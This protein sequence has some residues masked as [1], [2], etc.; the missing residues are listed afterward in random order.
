MNPRKHFVVIF[1]ALLCSVF[2]ADATADPHFGQVSLLLP[3]DGTHDATSTTDVSISG[4]SPVYNGDAKISAV[5]SKFGGTSCYFDGMGDYLI[6]ADSEDWNFGTGDFTIEFWVLRTGVSKF[7]GILGVNAAS[8]NSGAPVIVIYNTKILITEGDFSNKTRAA[9]SFIA[10]TWYHVAFSRSDGVMRL[11]VNGKLDGIAADAHSYD[12]NELRIGRYNVGADYDFG[13]YL[14]DIRITK[15]VA[16]YSS[17][18]ELPEAMSG[19]EATP[20]DPVIT[21]AK[22]SGIIHGTPLGQV[23]LNAVANVEGSF[24]YSP[25]AGTVLNSGYGQSLQVTFTPE[26]TAKYNVAEGRVTIDVAKATPIVTWFN[27]LGIEEGT[28]LD[29]TR[30]NATANVPGT[31]YYTPAAGTAL[32]VHTRL[33][34]TYSIYD[35]RVVFIAEDQSNYNAVG[36]KVQITVLPLAPEDAEPSILMEPEPITMIS[37]ESGQLSVTA[38]GEKPLA[39]QWYHNGSMIAGAGKATLK[40]EDAASEDGGDY[41]VV[42]M[43][44]L[45]AKESTAVTLTV[46]EPPV[47]VSDLESATIDIGASHQFNLVVEG[48]QPIEVEW[49]RNGEMLT[50]QDSLTLDI[51]AA[52]TTDGGEY[53]VRLKNDAGEHVS[54]PVKLSL[55][56]PVFI[57]TGLEDKSVTVGSDVVLK[58]LLQGTPPVSYKWYHDGNELRGETGDRLVLNSI[59]QLR[60][61]TYMVAAS[62]K[63]GSASSEAYLKV[64]SGP[65]IMR[66]PGDQSVNEG[67]NARFTVA[68]TGTKP[69][70]YQ[71]YYQGEAI[72]GATSAGFELAGVKSGNAGIYGVRISNF[73][74]EVSSDTARL[75]VNIPLKLVSDLEDAM[76]VIGG[77]ARF[78]VEVS[79]S[80]P[81]SYRWFKGG[82]LLSGASEGL[83]KLDQLGSEDS[84]LY[85]VEITN[86]AGTIRS[87]MARL[88]VV[89]GPT[90]AQAPVAQTVI[91]GQS[92][93]FSIIAGGSKPLT[94]Q[95]YRDGVSIEG[96]VGA[97][98][99]IE[100]AT[101]TDAGGYSV[102]VTNRGSNI[103]S[104]TVTLGVITPVSI[105]R[106]LEDVTVSEGG[107]ARFSVDASGTSPISYQWFYGGSP[108]DGATKSVY[109]IGIVAE[110]NR[111]IYQVKA[112]NGGGRASSAEAKLSVSVTPS[113]LR[114]MEDQELLAGGNLELQVSA[115]GTEP[116]TYNWYRG[117]DLYS[118]SSSAKL[119]IVGVTGQDGG[120]YQVEV[121]NAIGSV[122]STIVE[123]A[124]IEPATI[125]KHPVDTTVIQGNNGVLTVEVT[126]S[127]PINYQWYHNGDPLTG[128]TRA[129]LNILDAQVENSGTYEVHVSNQAGTVISDSVSLKLSIPPSITLQPRPFAGLTGE[130]LVIRIE[131]TGS[132]PLAYQWLKGGQAIAGQTSDSLVVE[133]VQE[134]DAGTYMV[135]VTNEAG[136]AT[137]DSALV[138]ITAPVAITAQ[139]Q[140]RAAPTGTSV[141]FSV[142]A[143]GTGSITYQWLKN[144][145]KITGAT[146]STYS[147]SSVAVSD[148]GGYQVLVSNGAGDQISQT[149]TLRVAQPVTIVTQPVSGQIRQGQ[150]YKLEVLASGTE[151]LS[152]QWTKDG[153]V[154]IGGTA[155][156]L[157]IVAAGVSDAGNYSVLIGNEVGDVIS[158]SATVEVL[159]PPSVGDM[160]ALK[161]VDPGSTV[162]LTTPVSG[163]GTFNYQWLKNGVNISGATEQTLVLSNVTLADSGSYS[164]NV[165]SEGGALYSNSMNLRVKADALAL[166]DAFASA[167]ASG[168]STGSY[169][170]SNVGAS[171]EVGEP[172]HGGRAASASV[173]TSWTAPANG[174]VSYSTQGSTFDTT[175]AVYTGSALDSLTLRAAD[176]DS[177]GYLTSRVRFNAIKDTVYHVAIDGFNGAT[178]DVALGWSL[179]ETASALPIIIAHPQSQTRVVGAQVKFD[180][181]LAPETGEVA[182]SW[183]KEGKWIVGEDSESL[184]LEY[185]QVADAGSYSVRVTSGGESVVSEVAQLTISLIED[186]PEVEV[187]TKLDLGAY[188]TAV[189]GDGNDEG[190]KLNKPILGGPDLLPRLIAKLR[191]I[192]KKPGEFSFAGSTV[193]NTT[194][195]A[196][197][198]GEPN[199]AGTTGGASAWTTFT[200][201]EEG[202]AKINTGN[203]DFDTVLAIYK[204]GSGT[205]WDAIEE[206]ASNND[207]GDDGQ[208]SE[209][210][211]TAEEGVTY[212]VAVDGVG[213]ETGTVQ[214]NHE[215]AKVP[216][217]D[218]VTE[219]A[220]G[221]LAGSVTLEVIAS[222][223]LADAEL[224]YQWRREGNLIDGATDSKLSLANLQY[225]DA[226]DYTVEVSNF[227]G[228]TTSDVIPVRV[229]QPV[230][231]ETQPV[232]TRGVVGGSVSLAVSAIGSDPITYQ[233]VH[234]GESIAGATSASLSLVNLNAAL[235][236][237]YQ[238]V[239]TNPTGSVLSDVAALA[240][241][242]PPAI[243]SL[244]GSTSVVAG[245][246][247]DLSVTASS[248]LTISYQ[249]KRDGIS[250]AGAVS[251]TLTLTSVD[252]T[253]AGDYTVEMT[254]TVGTT[255]S[256]VIQISVISPLVI[257]I[258]PSDKTLGQSARLLLS[259]SAVGESLVYQWYKDGGAIA[260]AAESVYSIS[261][262]TSS[263]SGSYHVTVSNTAGTV[264]SATAS[265]TVVA[266]PVIQ[267]QPI[268][269]SVSVGGDISLSVEAVGSGSVS[270]QWRQNGVVLDGQ[271]QDTLDLTG[272]KL[273]DEGSYSVEV[274][275][276]AGIT[277]SHAVDV[278]VLTPLAV[279]EHPQGQSVVAGALVVLDVAANGSN[280]VSYQWYHDGTAVG[281]ATGSSLQISDVSA[282][283]QGAYHV[284]LS[285][286]VSAVTSDSAAVVVNLPPGIATQPVGQPVQ[287]G[288]SAVFTVE[289]TGTA[290]FTYQWQH[291]GV[292]INGATGE[293][294][295]IDSVDAADDGDYTVIVQSAHGAVVSEAASLN[296]LLPLEIT[297]QP[298]D[299]HVAIASTLNMSVVVSG[300]GPYAYQWYY[301][302]GKINGATGS[303]L[304]IAGIA[305][306]NSGTYHV[307]VSN[308]IEALTSRDAEVIVDETI[309]INFQPV[310]T[311]IL[312]GES[313]TMFVL[314]SGSGPKTYQWQKDGVA[315]DGETS[316]TLVVEDATKADEGF[317]TI[318]IANTI[319]FQ[320][321]DEALLLVNAPPT[322][323]A[324]DPVIVST[325]EVYEVQVV[326]DDEGDLSKLRYGIQNGPETMSI[327]KG[328]LIE[329][330]VG[331]GLEG[332]AYNVNIHVIDQDG[333]AAGRNFAITVN[334]AP[335]WEDIGP[336]S[337]KEQNLLAFVPVAT[338]PDDTDLVLTASDLAVGA[339]YDA[340]SGFNWTPASNQVGTHDF[341]FTATDSHGVKSE[342]LTTVTVNANVA[343]TLAVIAPVSLLAGERVNM[344][345]DAADVDDDEATLV[346]TLNNAPEGMQV[347]EAGLVTWPTQTGTHSGEYTADVVVTDSLGASAGQLLKVVVN[348]APVVKS[349]DSIALKVGDKVEFTVVAADPEGGKLTYKALNNPDGFKGGGESGLNGKFN[350]TTKDAGEGDYKIDIEVADVAGLKSVIS[351]Q[352]SL[353]SNLAPTIEPMDSVVVDAGGSVQVQVVADDVDGDE[354][355]LVYTLNNAPEGMQVSEAGLVT[356]PTQTGTHS[357][358]YTADVVVTD[359]LGASAGQLLKV[360]VNGAPVVKSV[361]SIAL[362]VGDK[363][364]FTVVAA[365]P[366]G[367]KLTYKALN[368]P[369]GFKGGGESG[370]NG[371]FNWTTKDAGEGDYKIDIEVADVAGLKSVIS[372][373]I[374]LQSNLAPTIEPMDSVVVDAGGSVQVQVVA[375]DVDGDNS[376]LKYLLEDAQDGMQ[377]SES[378][379]I[380]W[381][382]DNQAESAD[383]SVT[384]IVLDDE[385]A[386]GKQVLEVSVK[387]NIPPTIEALEPVTIKTGGSIQLQVVADDPDGDNANL[388]YLLGDAP[389]GMQITGS[390]LVQW[391]VPKDAE[392]ATYSVT[393]STVDSRDG[394]GSS[395]LEVTVD[396]NKVPTLTLLSSPTVAGPFDPEAAAVIDESGQTITVAKTGGMRFYKLQSGDDAK[397]EITSIAIKDDNVVMSY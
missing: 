193:Y 391:L 313:A 250:V 141:I 110:T 101:D 100:S 270:F 187:S 111:G 268:G 229:V 77:S 356:W 128:G 251:S 253:D 127:E 208:D 244:T 381:S 103:E 337:G 115:S 70:S 392:V 124:V 273:S 284:V 64:N 184:V 86:P 185:L 136:S 24:E 368:N 225:S 36:K 256:D 80:G 49:Y 260:D 352:I 242:A 191:K 41:H 200:P 72:E 179:V 340:A 139:P 10:N 302:S 366:E 357:G 257:E 14:D 362:K 334:H 232:D 390:G 151:P 199:H 148:T 56:M 297:V 339:T 6:V 9:T 181:S 265:V 104:D 17:N 147:V 258:S 322:I 267:T 19:G 21:W 346:Y 236:G 153:V 389:E 224:T 173:W 68:V 323:A 280:P 211:F 145:E 341:R 84:G 120:F 50:G 13:G 90:I 221:L 354:A 359:S 238:V 116:L 7:E 310:G 16:R 93:E 214:L 317:Y 105:S 22:P 161:E 227:A 239:V 369:D 205:G 112:S 246:N 97:S 294:L 91:L 350:W 375:D 45:G 76:G 106:D 372:V 262:V 393:V 295:T 43:N 20:V 287:K 370:L 216:T 343:P 353:Q 177:G 57:V 397:L 298:K 59:N 303:E 23:Q 286:P 178:G 26:D 305:L 241:D 335:K 71:W 87:G 331:S 62:N 162:T 230:T 231:I 320:V 138:S 74:G 329:W 387:A 94:Y 3:F 344:R 98:L 296:V 255:V 166:R 122:R 81:V 360:V 308:T 228:A 388:K 37:G 266:P 318:I 169:R 215:L 58:V 220:D 27:P 327:S 290:P 102:L 210:V 307:K 207:G 276:E 223:P 156:T 159:L 154:V 358:E 319:G 89:A 201:D 137:S 190:G 2:I 269:G 249:W 143:T 12:F 396:A 108:I 85:Q 175:L 209:V 292:D 301:G 222:N 133:S 348:G 92:V 254:N 235:A 61:G 316:N 150:P 32:E 245:S 75:T 125:M 163:F 196:K 140:G 119:S 395:V 330:T 240:I 325:G 170:G 248:S 311:E 312:A 374:S 218:S 347:S 364:E 172:K 40:I 281:G 157:Q 46:L 29:D 165:G 377:I 126:G 83:L 243:S 252:S 48:S 60:Q 107:I 351:V 155:S 164:L 315:L 226:G 152:Y 117:G 394:M 53:F 131:A 259:V 234:N 285:N 338:D 78:K 55:N 219:S 349:V 18:F 383:Y 28:P 65:V 52:K 282:A 314:A 121:V 132:K 135:S 8:W 361:D 233:W 88:D 67:G 54:D 176:A 385:N 171:A 378:G 309:S 146:S 342:L 4:H 293:A 289:A 160:D 291:D 380:Q 95:W 299:T 31:F 288:G 168:G 212:L 304:E 306:S 123:V 96:A 203:S 183:L 328:G 386:M 66:Q 277:N 194:G 38:I 109:E 213:G 379:L 217:L 134:S 204:I 272:L 114:G 371:K 174:I 278:L 192:K 382:V 247:L 30:L 300:T 149:A 113:L 206:V 15:G 142:T 345:L 25:A 376:T 79:G 283:N 355:T 275:N 44:N 332:N 129:S 261:A 42:I 384:I 365:D 69:I 182:Y 167:V 373:Q 186:A 63:F 118:S 73:I 5:R 336:Q 51:S 263:D 82:V 180:V 363:V 202:A 326:A 237:D 197:D 198:P 264:T 195:A 47:L 321:S 189:Q 34:E 279:T 324:I 333:L 158:S 35:L 188:V 271:I 11:F 274:S 33:G 130:S 39:Y 99:E 367:G 1:I 144:G